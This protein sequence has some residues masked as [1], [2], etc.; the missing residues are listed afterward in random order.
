VLATLTG[1]HA[2]ERMRAL[3]AM[4]AGSAIATGTT[5]ATITAQRT[6]SAAI[7]PETAVATVAAAAP[8]VEPCVSDSR[9]ACIAAKTRTSA[10]TAIAAVA[11]VATE[12]APGSAIAAFTT[13]GAIAAVAAVAEASG[14]A[15]V[16]AVAAQEARVA[17]VTRG[18]AVPTGVAAVTTVVA[19]AA[20]AAEYAAVTAVT[21]VGSAAGLTRVGEAIAHEETGIRLAC[22]AVAEKHIAALG[23]RAPDPLD[24]L[25]DPARSRRPRLG[26]RL[27][28]WARHVHR[29]L[30][31]RRLARG[32]AYVDGRR[33]RRNR[34][35]CPCQGGGSECGRQ[36]APARRRHRGILSVAVAC[37]A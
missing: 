12:K 25:V 9:Y 20:I 1:K 7:A 14:S 2:P 24:R 5:V 19:V 22:R 31:A 10:G 18:S 17:A 16:A 29:A 37:P 6:A 21:D 3:L 13:Q 36:A 26:H 33:G 28:E 35:G 34:Q 15:T 23:R 11:A 30:D 32:G 4:L 8:W 27:D